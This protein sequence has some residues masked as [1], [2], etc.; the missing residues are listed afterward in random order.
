MRSKKDVSLE[1]DRTSHDLQ[2][3]AEAAEKSWR[4]LDGHDQLP[5]IVLGIKYINKN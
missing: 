2:A 5:K 1:Q 3:S 4:R